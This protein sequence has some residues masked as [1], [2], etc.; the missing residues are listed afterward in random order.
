MRCV[1]ATTEIALRALAAAEAE[2]LKMPPVTLSAD[3]L[4]LVRAVE[5]LPENQDGLDK[6]WMGK[7]WSAYRRHFA[8]ARLVP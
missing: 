6:S 3:H 7:R 5:A 2:V 4:Q 1:D 8:A